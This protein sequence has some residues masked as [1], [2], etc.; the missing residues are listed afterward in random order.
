MSAKSTGILIVFLLFVC[1]FIAINTY[2]TVPA[3]HEG[4]YDWFGTVSMDSIGAGPHFLN[5]MGHVTTFSLQTQQVEF[6]GITGTLTSEGLEVVPDAS[7]IY[8]L[9]PGF[10]PTVYRNV[11]GNFM[12]TLLTPIFMSV[13]RDEMK[14]WTAEDVYT[15]KA[16]QIQADVQNRMQTN[17]E[18]LKNGIAVDQVL[19][20]GVKL[21]QTVVDAI[22]SKIKESQAVTQMNFTYQKQLVENKQIISKAEAQAQANRELSASITPTLVSYR[23]V[24]AIASN[25]NTVIIAGGGNG[26]MLDAAGLIKNA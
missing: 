21:P 17:S 16:S 3:G 11:S 13:L 18:L 2:V 5:P 20:R 19:I 6:K 9:K 26:M 8:R 22:E 4:V 15:G 23:Y 25:P 10:G 24:D 1:G 14:K 7:L 12:D